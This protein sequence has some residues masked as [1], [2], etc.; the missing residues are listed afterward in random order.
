MVRH[1]A[2]PDGEYLGWMG[3]EIGRVIEEHLAQSS[4]DDDAEHAVKEHVV[5]VFCCPARLH[6]MR[7]FQPYAAQNRK[8]DEG[9]QIH[10]AV[11]V[12]GKRSDRKGDRVG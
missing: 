7:L 11:P 6:D 2:V 1:A 10:E 8:Q 12:D 9:Q 5:Q 4:A 3:K